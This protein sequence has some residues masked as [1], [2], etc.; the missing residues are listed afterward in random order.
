MQ[1]VK[2]TVAFATHIAAVIAVGA[3]L[4]PSSVQAQTSLSATLQGKV[5]DAQ[6]NQPIAGATVSDFEGEEG[7]VTTDSQGQFSTRGMI[8]KED[9]VFIRTFSAPGYVSTSQAFEGLTKAQST[10]KTPIKLTKGE[11][12]S[13]SG[14]LTNKG[15]PL[16]G[17]QVGLFSIVPTAD[18][19]VAIVRDTRTNQDGGYVFS[20]LPNGEYALALPTGPN[21][22]AGN[23][24]SLNWSSH[25][26]GFYSGAL[27][28]RATDIVFDTPT[29]GGSSVHNYNLARVSFSFPSGEYDPRVAALYGLAPLKLVGR[30]G[31]IASWAVWH[32]VDEPTPFTAYKYGDQYSKWR[33]W[34]SIGEATLAIDQITNV[35]MSSWTEGGAI[36]QGRLT[37]KSGRPLVGARV[38]L[39]A[40]TDSGYSLE[41]SAGITDYL[42]RYNLLVDQV[43]Y[44]AGKKWNRK[45]SASPAMSKSSSKKMAISKSPT[46]NYQDFVQSGKYTIDVSRYFAN[47]SL[48]GGRGASYGFTARKLDLIASDGVRDRN[49]GTS[50]ELLVKVYASGESL[51]KPVGKLLAGSTVTITSLTSNVNKTAKGPQASFTLPYGTYKLS[52]KD[53]QGKTVQQT[54]LLF[55]GGDKIVELVAQ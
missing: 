28:Y 21:A 41:E 53:A 54:T 15:K 50:G 16:T 47:A 23:I 13:I 9:G 32:I 48:N 10:L 12:N 26:Q 19:D 52:A 8:S 34:V 43:E 31:E 46:N 27:G 5:V 45:I 55:W 6:T 51:K 25:G 35:S 33:R 11:N 2:R 49:L 4:A 20:D 17:A 1:S 38:S 18:G 24:D 36:I 14:K 37:E 39:V 29:G 30:T 40:T 42:G 22:Y 7:S 44:R 3:L